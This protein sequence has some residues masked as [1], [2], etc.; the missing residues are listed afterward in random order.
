M[1]RFY[2]LLAIKFYKIW[3]GRTEINV[4]RKNKSSSHQMIFNS[5]SGWPAIRIFYVNLKTFRY[6]GCQ[7]D[8]HRD[9]VFRCYDI[10]A[11]TVYRSAHRKHTRT[12][13]G[14]ENLKQVNSVCEGA[15]FDI[16]SIALYPPKQGWHPSL[17][18]NE[19]KVQ[20]IP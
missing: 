12:H 10:L 2:V 8:Y 1:W 11:G 4:W 13:F 3:Q 17:F 20:V 7:R 6:T 16:K 14:K 5:N 15:T 19:N 18:S 9:C